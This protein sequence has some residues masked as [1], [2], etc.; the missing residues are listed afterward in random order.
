MKSTLHCWMYYKMESQNNMMISLPVPHIYL[1]SSREAVRQQSFESQ[2]LRLVFVCP[3][4]ALICPGCGLVPP[5]GSWFGPW[6]S[7]AGPVHC[8]GWRWAPRCS[9]A[10]PAVGRSPSAGPAVCWHQT[11]LPPELLLQEGQLLSSNQGAV[12]GL[13]VY[14]K[15]T[16]GK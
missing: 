2:R 9:S 6:L 11:D 1:N 5:G 3:S 13:N 10:A 12:A 4:E 16:T 14:R 7:G 15:A 8:A